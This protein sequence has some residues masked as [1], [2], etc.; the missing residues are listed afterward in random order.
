MFAGWQ[1]SRE[2][3]P[4][5]AARLFLR[6]TASF[7]RASRDAFMHQASQRRPRAR[8]TSAQILALLNPDRGLLP[9]PFAPSRPAVSFCRF[10]TVPPGRMKV[11]RC[12]APRLPPI[13]SG[14][15][16]RCISCSIGRTRPRRPCQPPPN[17]IGYSV[18]HSSE[19]SRQNS[20]AGYIQA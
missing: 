12:H 19:Q 8:R 4:E 9:H 2:L 18:D 20:P 6:D 17:P 7:Q 10:H 14:R 15:R 1:L 11:Y 13:T 5:V 16:G 3:P